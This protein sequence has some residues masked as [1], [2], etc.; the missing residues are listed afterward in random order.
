LFIVVVCRLHNYKEEGYRVYA[1]D[2]LGF[3]ASDKPS[4]VEYSIELWGELLVD[5]VRSKSIEENQSKDFEESMSRSWVVA[6]NSIGGLCCLFV[7]ATIP[8]CISGCVL[9][10]CAT[11]MTGCRYEELPFFLKPA[12]FFAQNIVLKGPL[13]KIFYQNFK[14]H[15][16]VEYFLK[17]KGV[18][19]D[20]SKVDNE[21]LEII[22]APANDIGAEDVFLK[23]FGGPP[24]PTPESILPSVKCPIL[25]LWGESD[26]WTPL[27]SGLHSGV[28][29]SNYS[30]DFTLVALPNTGHCPQ[31]SAFPLH[32]F[33]MISFIVVNVLLYL[34]SFEHAGRESRIMP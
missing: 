17:E 1:I 11:G 28:N 33:P 23:V 3:G 26:P 9:F 8:E 30:D 21:L 2:L 25:A 5:F 7:S 32:D 18:Y 34:A 4:D 20:H 29:L 16:N 12:L 27:T 14:S 10:N 24:G 31:V 19:N 6:G 22:L 13:G 15:E